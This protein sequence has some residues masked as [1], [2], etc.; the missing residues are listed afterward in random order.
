[1][2]KKKYQNT[3]VYK[4]KTEKNVHNI[5]KTQKNTKKY[6]EVYFQ[7]KKIYIQV[8]K[9]KNVLSAVSNMCLLYN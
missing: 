4:Y 8:S 5:T 6:I 2:H 9:Y 3:K 1:M 7:T